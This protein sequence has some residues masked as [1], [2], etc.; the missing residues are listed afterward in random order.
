MKVNDL[1]VVFKET[2][3]HFPEGAVVK[4]LDT[5]K[6]DPNTFLVASLEDIGEVEYK[7]RHDPEGAFYILLQYHSYWIKKEN[8]KR[9]ELEKKS[10]WQRIFG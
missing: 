9:I 1:A 4:I 6:D 8:C 3:P 5:S 10:L 7:N 2:T